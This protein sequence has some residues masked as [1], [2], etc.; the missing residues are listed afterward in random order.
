MKKQMFGIMFGV[1]IAAAALAANAAP[2]ASRCA[3]SDKICRQFEKLAQ[4]QQFEKIVDRYDTG[5]QYSSEARSLIGEACMALASRPNIT[6][7]EEESFYLG[8]LQVKHSIAYMGLYFLYAQKDEAKALGFLRE[9][10]KTKPADTV[11]YAILGETELNNKN[12]ELADAYLRQAKKVA[13]V[14]SPRIDWMLFQTNYL[15]QNYQFAKEMF[16]SAITY[17]KFEKELRAVA[18]DQRFDGIDKRP[19]FK[20]YQSML[21]VAMAASQR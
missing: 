13:N 16:A 9:Y 14:Y 8:A 5:T 19:E 18:A 1:T 7:A 2:Q 11:P 6:P 10:I 15:L 4:G 21:R 17:G 3:E 20:Q 12:Y